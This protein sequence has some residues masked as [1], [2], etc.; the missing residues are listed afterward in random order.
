VKGDIRATERLIRAVSVVG[1]E[2]PLPISELFLERTCVLS[3]VNAHAANLA[4]E[5]PAFLELLVGADV[6]LRDG[7]GM[8]LLFRWIGL[9]PGRNMNGTDYIPRILA[10]SQGAPVALYGSS[11][12][13]A[14][15][16]AQRLCA[17]GVNVASIQDGFLPIAEYAKSIRSDRPRVVV[18]GMGMPKQE[19]VAQ[20]LRDAVSE[21]VLIINGGAILDFL[22]NRFE[23]APLTVRRLGLE[24]LFRFLLEPRRLWRRYLL[25]NAAFLARAVRFAIHVRATGKSKP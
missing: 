5:N 21:P 19:M 6:L 7:I 12:E 11:R 16:A 8:S 9:D 18:L 20:H 24:W 1:N 13:V 23:R 3:F 10:A 4:C 15:A 2:M 17:E 22:A 14:D 25:G